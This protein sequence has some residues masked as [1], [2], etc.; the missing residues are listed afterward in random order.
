MFIKGENPLGVSVPAT[1]TN[2]SLSFTTTVY[3]TKNTFVLAPMSKI[4]VLCNN[5]IM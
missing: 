4:K 5:V 2:L 3:S 1:P